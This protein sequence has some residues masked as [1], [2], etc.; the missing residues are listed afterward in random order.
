MKWTVQDLVLSFDECLN[1]TQEPLKIGIDQEVEP[2]TYWRR[3]KPLTYAVGL[4]EHLH[5]LNED[6]KA[7]D[8]IEL[9]WSKGVNESN[10]QWLK[11]EDK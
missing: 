5:Y 4:I 6:R 3:C 2:A 9:D 1:D 7:D 10:R 8:K 11:D